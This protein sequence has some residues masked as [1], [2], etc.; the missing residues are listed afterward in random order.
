MGFRVCRSLGH[1]LRSQKAPSPLIREYTFIRDRNLGF[2]LRVAVLCLGP[3]IP[4]LANIQNHIRDP[5]I[6]SLNSKP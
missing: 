4:Q 2:S 5:G 3:E 6:I 1:L